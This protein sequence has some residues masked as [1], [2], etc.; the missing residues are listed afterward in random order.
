MFILQDKKKDGINDNCNFF[1]QMYMK[2]RHL[3]FRKGVFDHE[4]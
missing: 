3:C 2:F 4:Y 1:F